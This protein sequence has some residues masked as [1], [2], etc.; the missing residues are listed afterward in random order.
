MLIKYRNTNRHTVETVNELN[1]E[2]I[3][4]VSNIQSKYNNSS[5]LEPEH[6]KYISEEF[7]KQIQRVKSTIE[8]LI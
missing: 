3:V 6:Q 5:K 7:D 8:V 4:F 2:K 1:K